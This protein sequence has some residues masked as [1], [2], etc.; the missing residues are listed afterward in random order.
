MKT[1]EKLSLKKRIKCYTTFLIISAALLLIPLFI[2]FS[3]SDQKNGVLLIALFASIFCVNFYI[4]HIIESSKTKLR[5]YKYRINKY[6]Q[7]S[8]MEHIVYL[9]RENKLDEAGEYYDKFIQPGEI[10]DVLFGYL[11]SSLINSKNLDNIDLGKH[12]LEK[13]V[14]SKQVKFE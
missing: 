8:Y 14:E 3:D 1:T 4:S 5:V 12:K 6:R 7:Y 13:F 11:I 2:L 9:I 10:Q